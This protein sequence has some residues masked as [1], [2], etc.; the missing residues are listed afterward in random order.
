MLSCC[1]G[2]I[3]RAVVLVA[4]LSCNQQRV[5][6]KTMIEIKAKEV[7]VERLKAAG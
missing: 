6:R 2:K 4:V 5:Q 1:S 7:Q 3:R